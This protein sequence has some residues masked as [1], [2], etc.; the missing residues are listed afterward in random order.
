M[1]EHSYSAAEWPWLY[2]VRQHFSLEETGLE[3]SLSLDN[4][5]DAAMPAGLG[6]H[7]YC[8]RNKYTVYH[9]LHRGEWHNDPHCLPVQLDE[10]VA[11][12]DWWAGALLSARA[13]S[14]WDPGLVEQVFAVA[15]G[16]ARVRGAHVAL[17]P[18]IDLALGPRVGRVEKFFGE[19]PYLVADG[20]RRGSWAPGP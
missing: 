12:I 19:D 20:H 17:T 4:L 5:S 13:A 8:P 14:T 9:G 16:E 2:R 11:P 7:P 1:L 18:V 6:W 10:R 3:V 15:A